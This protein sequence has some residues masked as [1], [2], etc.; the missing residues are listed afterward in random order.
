LGTAHKNG[1]THL[2]GNEK[3]K[4]RKMG[5]SGQDRKKGC[6]R[7]SNTLG[8]GVFRITKQTHLTV[9]KEKGSRSMVWREGS[10]EVKN[11]RKGVGQEG[12]H[13]RTQLTTRLTANWV[14]VRRK[15]K[16]KKNKKKTKQNK[17][18][19]NT[20]HPKKNKKTQKK[21][22]KKE[23]KNKKKKKKKKQKKKTKTKKGIPGEDVSL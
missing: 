19:N 11:D 15:P 9:E 2:W 6:P 3:H 18:Q 8:G 20:H 13:R 21:K 17:K 1:V 5:R 14:T 10:T 23:K 12:S 7:Q 22:K 4:K 16:Q